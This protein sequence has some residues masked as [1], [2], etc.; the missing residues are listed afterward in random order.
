LA[1]L[2]SLIDAVGWLFSSMFAC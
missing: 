2:Q 1:H